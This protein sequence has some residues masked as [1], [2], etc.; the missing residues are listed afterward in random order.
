M[1]GDAGEGIGSLFNFL[2][3]SK[4]SGSEHL[5]FFEGRLSK[6]STALDSSI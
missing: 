4:N 5:I 1:L 2:S 3:E 6:S